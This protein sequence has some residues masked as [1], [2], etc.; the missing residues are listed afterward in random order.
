MGLV[1]DEYGDVQGLITLDDI[2]EEI[3]GEFTTE[4]KPRTRRLSTRRDGTLVVDGAESVRALNRRLGWNLPTEGARTLNGLLLERLESIPESGTV[5]DIDDLIMTI[6]E[7][8]DNAI[9]TVEIKP[10]E[11]RELQQAD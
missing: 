10:A 11:D 2:L 4:P 6:T 8:V 9:K 1:V 3:V 5:V 7:M